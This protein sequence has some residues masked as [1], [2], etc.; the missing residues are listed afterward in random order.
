[1][2]VFFRCNQFLDIVRH[3]ACD[4]SWQAGLPGL[5]TFVFRCPKGVLKTALEQ[6]QVS[7]TTKTISGYNLQTTTIPCTGYGIGT[8]TERSPIV[9]NTRPG[10]YNFP[11]IKHACSGFAVMLADKGTIVFR[12]CVNPTGLTMEAEVYSF[13]FLKDWQQIF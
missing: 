4:H 11:V 8:K 13:Q 10:I 9:Q 3:L 6:G 2:Q 1:M 12:D 5:C 7:A